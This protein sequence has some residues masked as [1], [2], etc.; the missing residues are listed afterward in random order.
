MQVFKF[1]GASVKDAESVRNSAKIISKYKGEALLVVISAMGKTT[2]L[3]EKLTR[4]YY[5]NTGLQLQTLEDAKAFHFQILQGLFPDG[6]HPIFDEIANCFVEIEW[7]LEE[8]PQDS[9]DY[10]FD[11]I[12]SM[13]ELI[14]TK[15]VAAYVAF[16]G[17]KVKWLDARD[18]ILTDNTYR[19]AA[20]DWNKTEEKIRAELPSILDEYIVITQGFLGSTSENFT[21]T[22]GREGSDYSAA[23][24][25]SCLNAENVTIWKDVP[26][27]LNADPKWFEK[28]ELIPELS[29]TDAIE[30]TYYG[31]TVI[32]PKTIKPL[33]NKKIA[34]N[35][36]SFVDPESPGTII[37]STNQTLPVPSFIFKVNQ[38]FISISPRDFSFIVEDN[39]RDIFNLFHEHRI[40]I[41]MMHNTAINFTVSV[42][43]TG[44]NLV[45]LINDLEQ[46]FKVTY[47]SGLELI[48]IRYY[49]Q[50]TIDRVLVDKEVISELKDR[51]TCQLLVK[52]I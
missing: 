12:V 10:L 50:E 30:L 45:D 11:Q 20:V 40:K 9:Y 34:L 19:E 41:N 6:E 7:I 3:L 31:A 36:R 33:Q 38:I 13:G 22:L 35:V 42:D 46:R 1:G 39:L 25:A 18:Y 2:N 14:S 32:H 17:E 4:E 5:N 47:E 23:I 37:R 51:Y 49:N 48:T 16:I 43:D 21:T 8:D 28:T 52:K 29:Y 24:F 44:K 26:G 27:V 15:I